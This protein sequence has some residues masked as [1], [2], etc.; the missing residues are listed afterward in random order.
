[1]LQGAGVLLAASK[2][3]EKLILLLNSGAGGGIYFSFTLR[4]HDCLG[5]LHHGSR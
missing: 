1:M 2:L 3:A 4:A 5:F